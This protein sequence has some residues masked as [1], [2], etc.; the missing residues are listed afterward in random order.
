MPRLGR[1]SSGPMRTMLKHGALLLLLLLPVAAVAN[2]RGMPDR[3]LILESRLS[4]G[5]AVVASHIVFGP[6]PSLLFGVRAWGRLELG[7]GL[8]LTRISYSLFM[9]ETSSTIFTAAPTAELDILKSND[10]KVALYLRAGL[11]LGA[12]FTTSGSRTGSYVAVGFEAGIGVRYAPHPMFT[13]GM[14]SGFLGTYGDPGGRRGSGF[15]SV[16]GAL[17]G[18]FMYRL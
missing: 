8:S 9:A 16:Y 4:G 7:V 11:P 3:A 15:T 2:E 12:L 18:T 17:V 14:E 6:L 5:I 1:L 10:D 13:I